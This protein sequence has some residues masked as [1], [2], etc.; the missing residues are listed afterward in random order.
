M[1][2]FRGDSNFVNCLNA[3][4]QSGIETLLRLMFHELLK[5]NAG[6]GMVLVDTDAPFNGVYDEYPF[7]AVIPRD[8]TI[9]G[10]LKVGDDY[11]QDDY[12]LTGKTLQSSDPAI[13]APTTSM[14]ASYDPFTY[15][16]LTQGSV[17]VLLKLD[18][19]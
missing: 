13:M 5:Q 17:W 19:D 16:K 15:I 11:V 6:D 1:S 3:N 18:G 10:Q 14:I 9:I 12:G 2:F 7:Y 8:D 4:K